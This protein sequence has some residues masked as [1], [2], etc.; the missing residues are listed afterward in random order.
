M[1]DYLLA[2]DQ[3]ILYWLNIRVASWGFLNKFLAEYLIYTI[4][5]VLLWL[6]FY[7]QKSKKVAMR[8][9][10]SVMLAWPILTLI[11]GKIVNRPRPF[12]L[13]QIKELLF[14]RPTY[15]F[16]SDH[17]VALF[18]LV[19]SFWLSGYKKLS[20][21]FLGVAIMVS[22]FRV[23][24]GLHFPSD[25]LAGA[26]LGLLAGWLVDLFDKPLNILYDLIIKLAQKLRLA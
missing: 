20:L 24:T 23:A 13:E 21:F 15:S 16:P 5:I 10:A 4:P 2:L 19:A 17:A 3:K 6:W 1:K 18:A 8:A 26:I 22:V 7:D 9:F 11:I 14:H 25:V 12:E